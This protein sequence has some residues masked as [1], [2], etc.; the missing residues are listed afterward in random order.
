MGREGTVEFSELGFGF[1]G[2]CED[3]IV[4]NVI[5]DVPRGAEYGIKYF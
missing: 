3:V 1:F 5:E 4:G 2:N